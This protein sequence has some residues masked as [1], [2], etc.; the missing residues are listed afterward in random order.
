MK[1]IWMII[2]CFALAGCGA[3]TVTSDDVSEKP[4][5]DPDA[6]MTGKADSLSNWYTSI[7]GELEG[8]VQSSI[9]YP[10]WF[11]GYTLELEA[12]TTWRIR[13]GASASGLVRVY[14]PSF[15]TYSNGRPYF[16]RS[17]ARANINTRRS[18][19]VEFDLP[20][21]TSGTYMVVYG[22]RYQWN[23]SYTMDVDCVDG[24]D[25]VEGCVSDSDCADGWCRAVDAQSTAR[26]CVP[27]AQEGQSCGGFTLPHYYEA[28]EPSLT[29]VFRPFVADAPG[30]CRHVVTVDELERNPD[31][32]DGVRVSIDG[33]ISAGVPMCTLQACSTDDPCCNACGASQTLTDSMS[34]AEGLALEQNGNQFGCSG[35]NCSYQ[36]NCT[37]DPEGEY[38]VVG[39][40][41]KGQYQNGIEVESYSRLNYGN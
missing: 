7:E 41:Q 20:V 25:E 32:W 15:A 3:D 9:D 12:G 16:T 4:Q 34:T 23:A 18:G 21:D 35:D 27:Y 19:E 2:L 1:A 22:P 5:A 40:F 13:V 24:C 38:R 37:V 33:W 6:E 30:A 39:V 14:G 28:C 17:I 8:S 10:D 36:D 11:H 29:C 26:E 31:D